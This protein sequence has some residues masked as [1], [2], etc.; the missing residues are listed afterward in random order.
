MIEVKDNPQK[1]EINNKCEFSES[2]DTAD[3]LFQ[4]LTQEEMK[5]IDLESV[6]N[7]QE[8]RRIIRTL[9]EPIK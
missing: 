9:S 8:I 5:A 7:M 2:E 1:I 4:R 3:H 6:D